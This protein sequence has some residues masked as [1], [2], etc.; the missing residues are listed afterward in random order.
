MSLRSRQVYVLKSRQIYLFVSSVLRLAHN[1]AVSPVKNTARN[2]VR[3]C[4]LERP[5]NT[6]S[7][8]VAFAYEPSCSLLPRRWALATRTCEATI[9]ATMIAHKRKEV[10]VNVCVEVSVNVSDSVNVS[11]EHHLTAATTLDTSNR[12]SSCHGIPRSW[13]WINAR[14]RIILQIRQAR[15]SNSN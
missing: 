12:K 5:I 4:D 13:C 10:S 8:W 15:V 14:P 1:F 3:A 6:P 2:R 9:I 11:F 7:S